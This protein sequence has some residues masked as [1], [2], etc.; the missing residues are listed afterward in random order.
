MLP[1]ARLQYAA[2]K[3]NFDL[4]D[5]HV[6]VRYALLV[7]LGVDLLNYRSLLWERKRGIIKQVYGKMQYS[8][9]PGT[10]STC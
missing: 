8:C 6:K 3:F 7:Y 10:F 9:I 5:M 4:W 2:R 1:S